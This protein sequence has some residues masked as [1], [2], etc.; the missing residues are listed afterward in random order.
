M[1]STLLVHPGSSPAQTTGAPQPSPTG[2]SSEQ[3]QA[4]FLE[5]AGAIAIVLGAWMWKRKWTY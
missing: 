4:P 1:P 5:A 2:A 3:Q